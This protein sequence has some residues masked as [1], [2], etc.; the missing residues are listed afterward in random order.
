MF[1]NEALIGI[2]AN[3]TT[4]PIREL[5]RLGTENSTSEKR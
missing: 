5:E 2:E 1:Y 3:T 4:Y